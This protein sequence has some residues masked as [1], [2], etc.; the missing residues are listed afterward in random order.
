VSSDAHHQAPGQPVSG[1]HDEPNL[2]DVL[3]PEEPTH[4]HRREHAK[5]APH[6][7]DDELEAKVEIEREEVG[8]DPEGGG[9]GG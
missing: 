4:A 9:P 2:D 8:L 5:A 1:R 3:E 6:P 7:D